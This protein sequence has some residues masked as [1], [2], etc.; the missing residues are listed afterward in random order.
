[1]DLPIQ[2]ILS[3][4]LKIA[5]DGSSQINTTELLQGM[6]NATSASTNV[7]QGSSSS[8][9][10][11]LE[12][13]MPGRILAFVPFLFSFA[14][15]RDWL[16]VLLIGGILETCR[17]WYGHFYD[18]FIES[19]W[20][21]ATFDEDDDSYRGFSFSL[22]TSVS[23]ADIRNQQNGSWSGYPNNPRGPRS[24]RSKSK[25]TRTGTT[26]PL[27]T[28]TQKRTRM[29][30]TLAGCSTYPLHPK[31]TLCGTNTVTSPSPEVRS[32]ADGARIINST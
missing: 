27:S 1:M 28:S 11:F 26:I 12:G 9:M 13:S 14:A 4:L 19:F 25:P 10:S 18:M 17:R 5:T 22:L 31:R 3:G 2:Q 15:L 8:S 6:L 30:P 21:S 20:M 7:T 23:L 24:D 16:K 32:K 29:Q